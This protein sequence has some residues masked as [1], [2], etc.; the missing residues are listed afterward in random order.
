MAKVIWSLPALNDLERILEYIELD[1]QKAAKILARKVFDRVGRL[2]TF[3]NSGNKP[4]DL[5]KTPFRQLFIDPVLVYHRKNS[6][7]VY[8]VHVT[9]A[10]REFRLER[11]IENEGHQGSGEH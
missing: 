4:K 6:D 3:P 1:N 2:E 9:R 10:E 8:I 7:I 5:K 11:I